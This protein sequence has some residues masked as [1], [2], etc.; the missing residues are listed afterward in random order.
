M[1]VNIELQ[2]HLIF[3]LQQNFI[4]TTLAMHRM[5][6]KVELRVGE[7]FP[8]QLERLRKIL[9][10]LNLIFGPACCTLTSF[11]RVVCCTLLSVAAGHGGTF[12][13]SS[14]YLWLTGCVCLFANLS[15]DGLCL[16]VCLTVFWLMVMCLP[17]N[18]LWL[19]VCVCFCVCLSPSF[20][21]MVSLCDYLVV[22]MLSR[23]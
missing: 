23:D 13:C 19:I 22:H 7:W 18:Y 3:K 5:K 6:E 10:L 14:P 8:W 20:C 12:V 15:F 2:Q 9:S 1:F 4:N 21:L 11:N 17:T 16:L